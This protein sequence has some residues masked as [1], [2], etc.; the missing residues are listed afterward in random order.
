[1]IRSTHA[2]RPAVFTRRT[3]IETA[4]RMGL[5]ATVS[6]SLPLDL[7]AQAT[8]KD[9]RLI[10]RSVRPPDFETPV[11]LLDDFITP[12]AAFFVRNHMLPPAVDK[13]SWTLAIDGEVASPETFSLADLRRMP[14]TTVTA[15]IECAG[16]GRAFFEP[17]VAGIQWG[18]GAVG[19]ARWTGVRVVDLLRRAGIRRDA[20]HV[21]MAGGD[22]PMGAQ[23]AFV[24]Q[25]PIAKALDVD[26][27]VAHSM[28]GEPLP[29]LHGS[30]FRVVVPAWEGAYSVKWLN[31]LTAA[32]REHDGFWVT[33]SYR[34]PTK[35]V[36]PGSVVA[37]QD[38]APVSGLVVKSL[39]TQP[40][41]G[42]VLAPGRVTVAGFAWAGEYDITRVD[43]SVDG[44]ASWQSARLTGERAKHAWRRF[45]RSVQLT[46]PEAYALLSRATDSRGRTQP[47]LPAWNP[48]GYLWN[49]PDV[50]RVEVRS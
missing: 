25:L 26:T 28:N 6:H 41:E 34:Y 39:I 31:R 23:P 12:V 19:T 43:I 11:E 8:D 33:G 15:T 18:R 44:G 24:R 47:V 13:G 2:R 20:T 10:T 27:L 38:M 30:P 45:E 32:T 5:A 16:N 3:W 37:A 40:L 36:A 49:A 46:R 14:A 17:P 50:V 22:R 48:A 35:R 9:P 29:L 42:A 21:W 1:M 7:I 4:A